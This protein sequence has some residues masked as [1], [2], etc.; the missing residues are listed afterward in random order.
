MILVE[1]S[2]LAMIR[3][4][5]MKLSMQLNIVFVRVYKSTYDFSHQVPLILTHLMADRRIARAAHPIINAWRCQVGSVLHQ[6]E[7]APTEA[8]RASTDIPLYPHRQR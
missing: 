2:Y 3:L 5:F 1:F 6:G 7:S 4:P 8:E